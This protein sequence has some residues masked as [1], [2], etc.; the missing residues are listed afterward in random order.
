MK[1]WGFDNAKLKCCSS[2][3]SYLCPV[4]I[5]LDRLIIFIFLFKQFCQNEVVKSVEFGKIGAENSER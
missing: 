1:I 5:N 2:P 3:V 4:M